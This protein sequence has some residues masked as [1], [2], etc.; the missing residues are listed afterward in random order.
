MVTPTGVVLPADFLRFRDRITK[1]TGRG[2]KA[3]V[4]KP[5]L[6]IGLPI[7]TLPS[8]RVEGEESAIK[9]GIKKSDSEKGAQKF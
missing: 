3:P 9:R 2:K 4:G 6:G 5:R 7:R 8:L 1:K